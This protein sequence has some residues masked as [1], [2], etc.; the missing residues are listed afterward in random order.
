MLKL[1]V[2]FLLIYFECCFTV[3]LCFG[4]RQME[5]QIIMVMQ[6]FEAG[7]NCCGGKKFGYSCSERYSFFF[8]LQVILTLRDKSFYYIFSWCLYLALFLH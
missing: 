1:G 2:H 3:Y 6:E 7:G 8:T 4:K 5:V